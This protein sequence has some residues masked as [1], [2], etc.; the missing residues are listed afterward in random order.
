VSSVHIQIPGE[1]LQNDGYFPCL[2]AGYPGVVLHDFEPGT[3]SFSIEALG[4]SDELLYAANGTV[5]VDGDVR[6]SIDL[7]P[8][9][10]PASFAYLTW[11][12]PSGINSCSDG[13]VTHV[14]VRI[15]QGGWTRFNCGAGRTDPGAHSVY[16]EP[17]SH[18]I[19]LVA[20]D[21]D[22]YANFEYV[23]ALQTFAGSPVTADYSLN[24]AIGGTAITWQLLQGSTPKTCAEAG[25]TSMVVHFVDAQGNYV[26]G[27]AGDAHACNAAPIVYGY[28]K[29]GTYTL[30]V[31][32][33]GSGGQYLSSGTSPKIVNVTAGVF[34]GAAQAQ[35]IELF[36][37]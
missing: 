17:G 29:P 30:Y 6:V 21:A 28:L 23:G 26:Y 1:A 8:P 19:H 35:T 9:G 18:T 34:P 3:Y 37:Q 31:S 27:T 5:T 15:D 24:W 11:S 10:Q 7:V 36:K 14:D 33:T 32:G 20:L 2:V 16:L 22:G 12:F 4:Y 25:V 13:D